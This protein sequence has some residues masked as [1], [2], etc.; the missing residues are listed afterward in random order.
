MTE[1]ELQARPQDALSAVP[2][3]PIEALMGKM[4]TAASDPNVDVDK[5]RGMFEMVKELQAEQ[6]RIAYNG[7]MATCQGAIPAI[8]KTHY[9]NQ[10][11]SYY[12]KVEDILDAIQPVYTSYGFSISFSELP[13]APDGYIRVGADVSHAGGDTRHFERLE[14]I[15]DKGIKGSV[16]KTRTHAKGSSTTYAKRYLLGMIF[17]L[18]VTEAGRDDDGNRATGK[19]RISDDQVL[20]IEAKINDNGLNMA[21]FIGWVKQ[22]LKVGRLE[23]IAE[24][25]F[26]N[27]MAQI[28]RSIK[29]HKENQ[30]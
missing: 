27:V 9:N 17:S 28:E 16:N 18:K 8:E 15:D 19:A 12:E 22:S 21:A 2:Q 20:Q 7:A 6:A 24:D 25:Q 23:D 11:E 1:Q 30:Q 14:P 4:I 5:M 10:T 3:A 13:D 29:R 26:D